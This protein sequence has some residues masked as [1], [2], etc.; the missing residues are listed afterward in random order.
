MVMTAWPL[1]C[2]TSFHSWCL[3]R[4]RPTLGDLIFQ[5]PAGLLRDEQPL[6]LLPAVSTHNKTWPQ[7][8]WWGRFWK[9]ESASWP[10]FLLAPCSYS[11]G[12][13]CDQE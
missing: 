12:C 1:C 4:H 6:W 10:L 8:F 13:Q 2:G 9:M 11:Y 5:G 3:P 7:G